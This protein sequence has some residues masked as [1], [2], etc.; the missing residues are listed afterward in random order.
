MAYNSM[1][2]FGLA[3][4]WETS[5]YSLPDYA[6]KHQGLSFGAIVFDVKTFEPIESVYHEIKFD[7]IYEWSDGAAKIHGLTKEHLAKHGITQEEAA[8]VLGNLAIKYWATTEDIMLLGHRVAFDKAFTKQVTEKYGINLNYHPT[9]LDTAVMGTI[10]LE[11]SKS[12][13]IFAL[14]GMPPRTTHNS[15]EDI[16][17]TL[18]SAKKMKEFFIAGVAACL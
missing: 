7:P 12:D 13:D 11:T 5:G 10:L 15:L 14:L 17:Y 2:K 6:A 18:D 1:P 16:M 9:M 3:I 8:L 4:D